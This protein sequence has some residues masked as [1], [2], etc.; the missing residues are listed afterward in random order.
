[1]ANG[2]I[3]KTP[4]RRI[5]TGVCSSMRINKKLFSESGGTTGGSK[6]AL[7]S[8]ESY[9]KEKEINLIHQYPKLGNLHTKIWVIKASIQ[10]AYIIMYYE[11]VSDIKSFN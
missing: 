1:M 11:L 6:R 8:I 9:N 3:K 4:F 10:V 5:G 2:P 7:R